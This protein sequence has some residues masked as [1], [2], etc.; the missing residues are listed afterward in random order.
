MLR[1]FINTDLEGVSGV[2][3]GEYIKGA[4]N[5]PDL[6]A[7]ARKLLA[8]DI[9]ACVSGC[10]DAGADV[11]TV[12]DGHGGGGNLKR[13]DIDDRANF[14]DGPMLEERFRALRDYDAFMQIGSHAMAGT[15]NAI[16]EHSFSSASI[17]NCWL[18]GK[19]IGE[20]GVLAYTAAEYGVPCIL[21]SG[22]DKAC[23]EA[24]EQIPEIITAEVKKAYSCFGGFFPPLSIT[25][26]LI[27]DKAMEAIKAFQAGKIP[28]YKPNYPCKLRIQLIERGQVPHKSPYK[29]IDTRTYEV[30]TPSVEQA[31]LQMW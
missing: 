24:R 10:F 4:L 28:L 18:N 23:A 1:V 5:R 9:N 21:V 7:E 30:E 16:L 19:P 25:H 17:Q 3:R 2:G 14:I 29:I 20:I 26:K 6:V 12:R 22:D 15:A 13:R 27:H 8:E 11:V 31:F